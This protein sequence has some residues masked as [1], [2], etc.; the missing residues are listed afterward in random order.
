[1]IGLPVDSKELLIHHRAL[2]VYA[3]RVIPHK[4]DLPLQEEG[5]R[6]R[7]MAEFRAISSSMGLTDKE[8]ASLLVKGLFAEE[9]G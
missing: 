9:R 4:Q 3:R 8:M 5:D 7:R 6:A 2:M 1:M